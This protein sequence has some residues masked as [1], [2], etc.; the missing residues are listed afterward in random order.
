LR[1]PYSSDLSAYG[2]IPVPLICIR[3]GE[4]PTALLT[5]GNH[6]DEYEGQVALIKLARELDFTQ[7]RG[8]IIILPALNF[9]AVAAGRRVSPIDDG[10]LNRVFPGMANGSP[11]EM[12]AHYVD[13]VLFALSDL[14]VDLHSGG[15]SLEYSPCALA[16]P[17]LDEKH[18]KAVLELLN[19]FG[20]PFSILTDGQGGGA[21]TTLY[22]AANQRRIPAITTELGGGAGLHHKT[23]AHTR[24]QLL[25]LCD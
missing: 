2:W 11:T 6:G 24:K 25:D 18:H 19:A 5:A 15:R 21:S 12:I 14:V 10:N 16:R 7:I 17:G 23:A 4:G 9:P 13:S 8:R 1:V 20:A 3:N 22:A